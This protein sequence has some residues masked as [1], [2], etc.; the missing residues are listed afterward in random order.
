MLLSLTKCK[1][2][3]LNGLTKEIFLISQFILESLVNV[4]CIPNGSKKAKSLGH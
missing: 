1:I 4:S 3:K 2:L